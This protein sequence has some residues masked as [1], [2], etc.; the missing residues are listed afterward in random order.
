[1]TRT[2]NRRRRCRVRRCSTPS[3]RQPWAAGPAA[4]GRRGWRGRRRAVGKV[5]GG[6]GEGGLRGGAVFDGR[7]AGGAGGG[8]MWRWRRT[9]PSAGAVAAV[10]AVQTR[11]SGA[12]EGMCGCSTAD[13]P[14]CA[15]PASIRLERP[16]RHRPWRKDAAH[17][18][19][20]AMELLAAP[21]AS[22]ARLR[23][24]RVRWAAAPLAGRE[25]REAY[26]PLPRARRRGF[27]LSDLRAETLGDVVK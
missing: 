15:G 3:P 5:G 8:L 25:G 17:G 18:G 20:R 26:P 13:K 24:R 16:G 2:R 6:R 19:R 10:H 7:A 11:G 9:C 14:T 23:R 12:A 22:A 1:M 4:R 27:C 21:A